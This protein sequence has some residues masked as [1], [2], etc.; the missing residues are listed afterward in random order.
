MATTTPNNTGT[1]QLCAGMEIEYRAYKR[2]YDGG[3]AQ[4]LTLFASF[5]YSET[6]HKVENYFT[7]VPGKEGEKYQLWQ[8]IEGPANFIASYY[9]AS[10]SSQNGLPKLGDTVN[11]E[12]ASGWHEVKVEQLD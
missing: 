1:A 2:L 3:P 12:D 10:Y 8:L 4:I 5:A 9:A 6:P 7:A 11:I